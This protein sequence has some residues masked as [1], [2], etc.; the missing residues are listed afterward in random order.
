MKSGELLIRRHSRIGRYSLP[1]TPCCCHSLLLAPPATGG[2]RKRPLSHDLVQEIS[3][4]AGCLFLHLRS[5]MGVC[6]Q[7]KGRVGVSQDAGQCFR[8]HAAGESMGCEGVS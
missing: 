1:D 3:H 6:I 4:D 5:H 8:I 2:A 7:R